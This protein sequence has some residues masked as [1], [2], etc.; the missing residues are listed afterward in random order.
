MNADPLI[1]TMLD[2]TRAI[3]R[4]DFKLI[5]GGGFGLYLKQLHRQNGKDVLTL[6][7]GELW[8]QPRATE[9]LDVFLPTE[10]VIDLDRMRALRGALD[11]LG[12]Q[13]VEEARFLQFAKPWRDG[14]GRIK[15]DLLTGPIEDAAALARVR[16]TRPRVRPRGPLELHAYLADEAVEFDKS[17]LP[18]V[19]NAV[20]S[21]GRQGTVTIHIPQPFTFLL[22]KLHAFADRTEDRDRDLGRHHALD[23]YRIVAMLTADEYTEVRAKVELHEGSRAVARAREIVAGM[24]SSPTALGAI[25]IREHGLFANSTD[26]GPFIAALDDLFRR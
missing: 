7:R 19:I 3:D 15:I 20:G 9:D 2:L 24:F 6:I 25:R 10:I 13:P 12:F 18:L 8:P 5:L 14:G 16:V 1:T 26:L 17:L 22:M 23:V 4:H 21:D 11:A